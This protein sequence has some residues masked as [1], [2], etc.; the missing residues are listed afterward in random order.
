MADFSRKGGPEREDAFREAGQTEEI[1]DGLEWIEM[2]DGSGTGFQSGVEITEEEPEKPAEAEENAVSFEENAGTG[3][4]NQGNGEP[5]SG[6]PK[7]GALVDREPEPGNKN[8]T[9]GTLGAESVSCE[10]QNGGAPK[11]LGDEERGAIEDFMPSEEAILAAAGAAFEERGGGRRKGGGPRQEERTSGSGR[12]GEPGETGPENQTGR[13]GEAAKNRSGREDAI[14]GPDR[15]RPDSEK[16]EGERTDREG[17]EGRRTDIRTDVQSPDNRGAARRDRDRASLQE[18]PPAPREETGDRGRSRAR[19]RSRRRGTGAP[20]FENADRQGGPRKEEGG[21]RQEKGFD[22]RRA[23]AAAIAAAAVLAVGGISYTALGQ[24]YSRV[25]FPG[26]EINGLD[27]SGKTAAEAEQMIAEGISGYVLTI[28]ERGG[29]TERLTQADIG[30]RAEFDGTMEEIIAAQKPLSWGAYVFS[31]ASYKIRTMMVYD[32]EAFRTA[33]EALGCFDEEKTQE[34]VNARLSD[35]VPGEGYTIVPEKEGTRAVYDVVEAGIS[36]AILK[37]ETRI[38]LEEIGGYEEPEIT[39]EDETLKKLCENMNRAA[40]V[41]ITY[42]FGDASETLSGD[43]IKDW[44]I[45]NEDGTAGVDSGKVKAYVEELADKYN[46]GNKAKKLKTSYGPTVTIKGGTYGWK[47]NQPAEADELAALIKAGESQ[48]GR[49][50]VYSQKAAS[51]GENDYGDTYVEINLTAQ[52]LFFYKDGALLVESDFVSGNLAKGWGTP[53]GAY[54]LTYK[55]RDAVLKGEGYRTPVDYWMPFNG[56]IGM[57][58]ATWRSSFGGTIYK[59]NGSHGCVN[60]PHSVAKKIYENIQAGMPVLC[61][62]LEGTEKAPEKPKETEPATQAPVQPSEPATQAPVQPSEP[63]SQPSEPAVQPGEPSS[64]PSEPAAQPQP[65]SEPSS[66][67]G[68]AG[69]GS[70]TGNSGNATGPGA[71]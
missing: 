30:L 11:D 39:S 3:E 44:L 5:E 70:D 41:T 71:V 49:E 27:V 62:N 60:L 55:Q 14:Q 21:R 36:D 35:Y 1:A 31:P 65:P 2:P 68:P 51:H 25:F 45:Q 64:Q 61:Y 15:K 69:P 23:A 56:G 12:A 26:T 40:G 58:D 19:G 50:P 32:E 7:D 57:H 20:A 29:N 37:L 66:E 17:T 63:P 47:I 10:E 22:R 34:P 59:T 67:A 46:T 13:S 6:E 28:E 42:Q 43:R 24:K 54:P 53:A 33:V 9:A 52:H 38:S 4:K 48:S 8:H 16:R 18:Q